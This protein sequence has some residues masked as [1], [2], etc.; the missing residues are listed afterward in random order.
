MGGFNFPYTSLRLESQQ[1]F[2]IK[3][4]VKDP[5]Q[6]WLALFTDRFG[7]DFFINY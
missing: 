6:Q 1:I 7:L 4:I 5:D 3:L 2:W